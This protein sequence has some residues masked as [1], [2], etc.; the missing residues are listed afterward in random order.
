MTN[1]QML[2]YST[3]VV[4][5]RVSQS[6]YKN[7]SEHLKTDAKLNRKEHPTQPVKKRPRY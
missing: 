2:V 3:H 4:N 1:R 5:A 6:G 7:P